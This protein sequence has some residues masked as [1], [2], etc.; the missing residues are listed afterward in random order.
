MILAL[1]VNN[2][3]EAILIWK[4]VKNIQ[5]NESKILIFLKKKM[6]YE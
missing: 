5:L 2:S 3:F 1:I 6:Q 4:I